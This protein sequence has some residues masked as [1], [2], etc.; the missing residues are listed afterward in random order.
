[1]KT[2]GNGALLTLLGVFALAACGE[3]DRLG[4][5]VDDGLTPEERLELEVLGDPG[6]FGVALE[7]AETT[8]DASGNL[9]RAVHLAH[10]AHWSALKAVIL[11]GGVRG[12]ETRALVGAATDLLEEARESLGEAPSKLEL[13]LFERAAEVL[14]IGVATLEEGHKRGVAAVWRSAVISA[15]LLR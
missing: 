1:M 2:I 6:S 9:R 14:E 5:L 8:P 10:H 12:E 4:P 13:R 3:T 7:L 15:W 11:S